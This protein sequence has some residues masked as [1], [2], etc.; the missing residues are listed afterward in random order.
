MKLN[1]T[2]A[3]AITASLAILAHGA[4]IYVATTGNDAS[5][6]P[7]SDLTPLKTINAAIARA[8]SG[9]V[10]HVAAG[11]YKESKTWTID[12]KLE[13]VGAGRDRTISQANKFKLNHAEAV[14]RDLRVTGWSSAGAVEFVKG[15]A[16]GTMRRCDISG[17]TRCSNVRPDIGCVEARM[18]GL[19]I[20]VR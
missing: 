2:L 15:G 11:T 16:G 8:N 18:G 10:I 7:S 5:V 3:A 1:S 6:D 12:K 9:D 4:D 14:I 13:I 20:L 17:N 19:G